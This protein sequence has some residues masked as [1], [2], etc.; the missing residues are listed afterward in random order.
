MTEVL[1][2]HLSQSTLEAVLPPLLEKSL[3]RGWNAVVQ[4]GSEERR[5][6]LN[7]LLWTWRDDSFIGHGTDQE[8]HAVH[9]PVI[10]TV[11]DANPN[12]ARIRFLVDGARPPALDSYERAVLM[13]DGHDTGQI[14]A[15]RR[16][17]KRLREEG[18]SV[19]YWQQTPEGRWER[20]A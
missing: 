13:F 14:E 16:E 8:S 4:F 17:W 6:A 15:A 11:T 20:R 19:T 12:R 5:D 3:E 9:Q 10:L 1:F 2:Y 7:T 18:H